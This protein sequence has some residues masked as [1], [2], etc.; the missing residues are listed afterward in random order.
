M[1]LYVKEKVESR[2]S[3][4]EEKGKREQRREEQ[5]KQQR[6][7]QRKQQR[8]KAPQ[9]LGLN[10]PAAASA[11]SGDTSKF[12]SN[13]KVDALDKNSWKRCHTCI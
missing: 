1:A 4:R 9:H 13:V 5:S 2:A 3:N 6:R 7:E 8:R 10:A 11:S 12:L